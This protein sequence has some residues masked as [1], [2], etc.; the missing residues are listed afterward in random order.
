MPYTVIPFH[1]YVQAKMEISRQPWDK[2]PRAIAFH[3]FAQGHRY[4][5]RLTITQR[6]RGVSCAGKHPLLAPM[7]NRY[8]AALNST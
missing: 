2:V 5:L 8:I 3:T 6:A 7:H 1:M 4:A